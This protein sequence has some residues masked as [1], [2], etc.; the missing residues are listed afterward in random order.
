MGPI[1]DCKN[2]VYK[3]GQSRSSF[4]VSGVSSKRLTSSFHVSAFLHPSYRSPLF[5]PLSHT[6]TPAP[7]VNIVNTRFPEG[8]APV[9]P[10]WTKIRMQMKHV[11]G[12]L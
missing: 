12:K 6:G 7:Y 1:G 8:E 2:Y 4:H 10:F 9:T 5:R 3:E 11:G